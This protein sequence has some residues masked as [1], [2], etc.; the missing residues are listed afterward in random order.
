MKT[1]ELIVAKLYTFFAPNGSFYFKP[2]NKL[3][4]AVFIKWEKSYD[5]APTIRKTVILSSK[6]LVDKIVRDSQSD[7]FPFSPPFIYT[8][9]VES[10]VT[11]FGFTRFLMH[12]RNTDDAHKKV[13]I[14]TLT[15]TSPPLRQAR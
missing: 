3:Y 15:K 9:K 2:E 12:S 7:D 13:T 4:E 6:T 1:L 14:R 11:W 10:V 8:K 5:N